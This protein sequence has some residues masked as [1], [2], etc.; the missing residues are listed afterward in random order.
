[1]K[2]MM[3]SIRNYLR[4][5]WRVTIV[6][7]V[8]LVALLT[9]TITSLVNRLGRGLDLQ[10][11][12]EWVERLAPFFQILASLGVLGGLITAFLGF[13]RYLAEKERERAQRDQDYL[14]ALRQSIYV[15]RPIFTE[16]NRLLKYELFYEMA[17]SVSDFKPIDVVLDKAY[18]LRQHKENYSYAPYD[19]ADDASYGTDD[20]YMYLYSMSVYL[21]QDVS[22]SLHRA[23]T[24]KLARASLP[25]VYWDP[26]RPNDQAP[27]VYL[28]VPQRTKLVE[29]FESYTNKIGR[30]IEPY[31]FDYPSLSRVLLSANHFFS[32]LEEEYKLY[33]RDT[34]RWAKKIAIG[35]SSYYFTSSSERVSPTVQDSS[36]EQ[37]AEKASQRAAQMKER[38]KKDIQ[39]KV[40]SIQ[41]VDE[42]KHSV[43]QDVVND[44][45]FYKFLQD[46][47]AIDAILAIVQIVTRAYLSKTD[48]DLVAIREQ[49]RKMKFAPLEQTPR[50]EQL[51]QEAYNGL[52]PILSEYDRDSYHALAQQIAN[53]NAQKTTRASS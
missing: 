53:S 16:L 37:S 21:D 36:E 42:F 3:L 48:K 49:E 18:D 44:W 47:E 13:R 38:I 17:R 51:L 35:A 20:S 11:L 30:E 27:K 5:H 19:D 34:D 25:E 6:I 15:S 26:N 23:F 7:G 10:G 39:E 22:E 45:Y 8:A 29:L 41:S 52:M 33:A 32:S 9:I 4:G 50:P 1:M 43:T 24:D 28:G 14:S 31:R 46:A 12:A 2:N 40:D